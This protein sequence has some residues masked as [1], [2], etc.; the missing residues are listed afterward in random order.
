MLDEKG[1]D[2]TDPVFWFRP[3]AHD[4]VAS[5]RRESPVVEHA[6]AHEGTIWSLFSYDAAT[7]VLDD[8]EVFSSEGGSL[9]GTGPSAPP[10]AGKM[11]ALADPPRHRELRSPVRPFFS[12]KHV[13][14]LKARVHQLAE[15]VVERA[16]ELGEVEF[17]RDVASIL[18]MEVMCD[19]MGV[20]ASDRHDVVAMCDSA[21]LGHTRDERSAGHLRLMGYLFEL[22]LDRRRAPRHDIV[23]AV[24]THRIDGELLPLEDVVLNCDNVLVGGVQTV[25]HAASMGLHTLVNHPGAWQALRGGADLDLAVEELLRWTSVGSHTVRTT[26][27]AASVAG[28]QIPAGQRLVVWFTSAN[29]DETVFARA[30]ELDLSRAN[31]RHLAFGAGLHYCIGAHL[32]RLELRILLSELIRKVRTA[33]QTGSAV[34]TPSIIDLGLESLPLKLYPA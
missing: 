22:A 21:F 5:L 7:I 4:L 13:G 32:A 29:R 27:R 19:L 31:N 33:E 2:P 25:R 8:P 9:L 24:A 26:K 17:V 34:P 23:S 14:G 12:T 1:L 20:P 16:I 15:R 10:G 3:D 30:D 18:P 6:T 28:A 11:M